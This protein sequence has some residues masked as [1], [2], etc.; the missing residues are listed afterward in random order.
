M[1]M[2]S[3][4]FKGK[5]PLKKIGGHDVVMEKVAVTIVSDVADSFLI[6][7]MSDDFNSTNIALGI[8]IPYIPSE[9]GM[10]GIY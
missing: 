6:L 4:F 3:A 9:F 1:W 5:G 10:Q 8:V 2:V 7:K